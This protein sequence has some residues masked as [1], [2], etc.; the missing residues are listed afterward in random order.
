MS[1][2]LPSSVPPDP[3]GNNA[4]PADNP[5]NERHNLP[6][7]KL[8]PAES[9]K[10]T[11]SRF[12]NSKRV[13]FTV[14]LGLV[15]WVFS[16]MLDTHE[17]LKLAAQAIIITVFCISVCY[18][19]SKWTGSPR[20]AYG[21]WFLS[22]AVTIIFACRN[23]ISPSFIIILSEKYIEMK[24]PRYFLLQNVNNRYIRS[25]INVILMAQFTNLRDKALAIN[26]YQFEGWATNGVWEI[27]PTIDIQS[28][29]PV[30]FIGK[31]WGT[32]GIGIVLGPVKE[33]DVVYSRFDGDFFPEA[34]NGKIIVPG[35]QVA[36]TFFLEGPKDG[37]NG[38]IR[39]RIKDSADH[40][41]TEMVSVSKAK[42]LENIMQGPS[43]PLGVAQW[44]PKDVDIK[45]VPVVPWSKR[46]K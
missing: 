41:F 34:L 11:K 24:T 27:M 17:A 43:G 19:L 37:F 40:E 29:T 10:R 42:Y 38:K 35:G 32:N 14:S 6:E 7:E 26:S 15:L 30:A 36:G 8:N 31:K 33:G 23:S 12:P 2:N 4:P 25:P 20:L 45:N 13:E 46:F 44:L 22:V 28:G 3:S 9:K 39:C 5:G 16:E 18:Y 1:E 21:I